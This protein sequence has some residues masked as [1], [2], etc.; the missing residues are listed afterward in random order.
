MVVSLSTHYLHILMPS[1]PSVP[2]TITSAVELPSCSYGFSSIR[3]TNGTWV[4]DLDRLYLS[5]LTIFGCCARLSDDNGRSA[6]R[7]HTMGN[8]AFW[9]A[10]VMCRY[11]TRPPQGDGSDD[12]SSLVHCILYPRRL[13][14]NEAFV[15]DLQLKVDAARQYQARRVA[16]A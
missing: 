15:Q 2:T 7:C 10:A 16:S 5:R 3:H 11:F 9:N 13:F 14:R 4:F 1:F 8:A 6:V 12:N